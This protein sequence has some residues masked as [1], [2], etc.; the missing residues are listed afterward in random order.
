LLAIVGALGALFALPLGLV[1]PTSWL[2]LPVH[3]ALTAVAVAGAL[4]EAFR[5][6]PERARLW[7]FA[8][9]LATL[10]VVASIEVG[11]RVSGGA[12][13]VV[14]WLGILAWG[15]IPIV[16]A[17]GAGW[18]GEVVSRWRSKRTVRK[19]HQELPWRA[20]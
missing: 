8:H 19:R 2:L 9:L 17:G 10:G 5:G 6:A 13:W 16:V 1:G 4:M 15:W 7:G 3:A 11:R 12:W 18:I 20:G 14:P